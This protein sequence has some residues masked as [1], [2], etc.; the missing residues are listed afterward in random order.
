MSLVRLDHGRRPKPT[1]CPICGAL[2]ATGLDAS[3]HIDYLMRGYTIKPTKPYHTYYCKTLPVSF[4]DDCISGVGGV[5][6]ICKVIEASSKERSVVERDCQSILAARRKRNRSTAINWAI[7]I[8]GV[9]AVIGICCLIWSPEDVFVVIGSIAM[10]GLVG[11]LQS[12]RR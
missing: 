4:C 9:A 7:G 11:W 8:S 12:V 5:D 1:F 6:I 3:G 2:V 10:L